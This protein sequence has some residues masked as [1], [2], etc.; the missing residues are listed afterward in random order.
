M[1]ADGFTSPLGAGSP[2]TSQIMPLDGAGLELAHEVGLQF[3]GLGDHQ[4]AAGVPLS[5]RCIDAGPRQIPEHQ[6]RES[7]ALSKVPDQLPL[8][9]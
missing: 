9:G 5:R 3:E 7:S 6:R 1:A 8:P 2:C 4:Q